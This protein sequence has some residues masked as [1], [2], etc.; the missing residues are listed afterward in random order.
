MMRTR[1]VS[2]TLNDV[3]SLQDKLEEYKNVPSTRAHYER[4][5][6]SAL[7]VL[8]KEP[9]HVWKPIVNWYARYQGW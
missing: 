8:R 6:L 3:V 1:N 4:E 2:D 9:S 5:Y 7:A